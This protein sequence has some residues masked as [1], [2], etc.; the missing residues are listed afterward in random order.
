MMIK[1]AT[2]CTLV[3]TLMTNGVDKLESKPIQTP[4]EETCPEVQHPKD[5]EPYRLRDPTVVFESVE[6]YNSCGGNISM[7]VGPGGWGLE[8][9]TNEEKIIDFCEGNYFSLEQKGNGPIYVYC[10]SAEYLATHWEEEQQ[11]HSWIQ[12]HLE[13]FDTLETEYE[14][15]R[16]TIAAVAAPRGFESPKE[17]RVNEY[18]G[19]VGYFQLDRK[20]G[21]RVGLE[22][23]PKTFLEIILSMESS[24]ISAENDQ[25]LNL[26]VTA[27]KLAQAISEEYSIVKDMDLALK[28]VL[29]DNAPTI[30]RINYIQT[31]LS[32]PHCE[33]S[34][35]IN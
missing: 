8:T 10:S 23:A 7:E 12:K 34:Y 1:F 14:L 20:T 24:Q 25:R 4:F 22:V 30:E 2:I 18:T 26:T 31:L 32:G 21:K 11:S 9:C 33:S 28:Q 13:L 19:E 6:R 29:R 15:P 5:L 17:D 16:G 35:Q 27:E 3:A